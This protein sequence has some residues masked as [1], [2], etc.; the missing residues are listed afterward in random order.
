MD[1]P[2]SSGT[3]L[4][5]VLV[6]DA[7]ALPLGVGQVDQEGQLEGEVERDPERAYRSRQRGE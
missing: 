3:D 1:T 4:E 6:D 2:E 5:G 7:R